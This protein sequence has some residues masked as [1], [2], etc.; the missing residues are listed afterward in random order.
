MLGPAAVLRANPE[1]VLDLKPPL[2]PGLGS[3]ARIVNGRIVFG[4]NSVNLKP[5]TGMIMSVAEG[6]V[7]HHEDGGM[8]VN[9]TVVAMNEEMQRYNQKLQIDKMTLFSKSEC[10]SVDPSCPTE[11]T[12][13]Q[14]A[15]TLAEGDVVLDLQTWSHQRLPF[16]VTSNVKTKAVGSL[17]GRVFTGRFEAIQEII[18]PRPFPASSNSRER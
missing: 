4:E 8:V 1:Y 15:I 11:F 17:E 3:V 14:R 16:N 12:S 2:A 13:E 9:L 6:S 7:E 5:L 10:L 18:F